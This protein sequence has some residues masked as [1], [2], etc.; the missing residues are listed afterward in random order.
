MGFFNGRTKEEDAALAAAEAEVKS[1]ITFSQ[2]ITFIGGKELVNSTALMFHKMHQ[3]D[4]GTVC[5]NTAE[6]VYFTI[7]S[8]DF[9]GP[10]YHEEATQ[11]TDTKTKSK[12]KKKGHGLLGAAIGTVAL[13]P[14]GTVAGAAIGAGHSKSKGESNTTGTTTSTTNQVEDDSSTELTLENASTGEQVLITLKTKTED[15]QKLRSFKVIPVAVAES[16]ASV[17]EGAPTSEPATDTTPAVDPVEE[18][19]RY[20]GLLDD[21]I[22]EQEDFDAKKKELLGL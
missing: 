9:A 17:D 15:Y 20:K 6:P 3:M 18:L 5:F 21:G 14:L 11:Q 7:R 4:D 2:D 22:I 1:H 16:A 10:V 8:I 19:R 13:G 12:G